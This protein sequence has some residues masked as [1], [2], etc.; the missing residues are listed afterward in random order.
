MNLLLKTV[1]DYKKNARWPFWQNFVMNGCP[2]VKTLARVLEPTYRSLILG[3]LCGGEYYDAEVL[4]I[5]IMHLFS[6]FCWF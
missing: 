3:I 1:F 5:S 2:I 6:V 4:R